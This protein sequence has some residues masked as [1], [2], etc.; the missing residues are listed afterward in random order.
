MGQARWVDGRHTGCELECSNSEVLLCKQPD[1]LSG[2]CA[3]K[4]VQK[5]LMAHGTILQN[6]LRSPGMV[7]QVCNPSRNRLPYPVSYRP[8]ISVSE[9]Q[10]TKQDIV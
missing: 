3:R 2:P 7:A 4:S 6:S 9:N 1:K 5:K 10:P 8:F